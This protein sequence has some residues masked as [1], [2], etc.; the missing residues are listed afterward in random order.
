MLETMRK[1]QFKAILMF[2]MLNGLTPPYLSE[3]FTHSA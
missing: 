1:R 2:K 3:M